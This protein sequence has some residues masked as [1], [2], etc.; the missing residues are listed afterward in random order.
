MTNVSDKTCKE[1]Q[2]THFFCSVTSFFP[3]NRAVLELQLV[4]GNS[5]T[6]S[7][8]RDHTYCIK[9]HDMNKANVAGRGFCKP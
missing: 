2:N 7:K 4:L 8:R 3:K 5:T 9:Q 1:S 6:F